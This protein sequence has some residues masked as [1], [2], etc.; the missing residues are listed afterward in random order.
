MDN[1]LHNLSKELYNKTDIETISKLKEIL[2][3]IDDTIFH[4]PITLKFNESP[5][6]IGSRIALSGKMCSG[7]T[8]ASDAFI[9]KWGSFKR[10]S[11]AGR[12]KEIA[13][14]L[15]GMQQ[16][17]RELL[18]RLGTDIRIIDENAWL[19]VFFNNL[20][21]DVIC[22]DVRY[23]NE[24]DEL[25]KN[26]FIT[27][28]LTIDPQIQMERIKELYPGFKTEQLTHKSET[29]LD[30]VVDGFHATM[31]SEEFVDAVKSVDNLHQLPFIRYDFERF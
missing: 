21:G 16:K 25:N 15:F 13:T 27:V 11:I 12:L 17:D 19:N 7:K 28:R 6:K 9:S 8:T 22:D 31:T 2:L 14:E 3:S 1:L 23:K 10:V 29:D 4:R 26:G 30:G 18:Q 5:K 24:L 20:N